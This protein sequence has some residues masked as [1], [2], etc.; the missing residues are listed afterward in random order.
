MMRIG[1]QAGFT[2][3][4]VIVALA[5][6]A[7]TLGGLVKSVGDTASNQHT[8]EERTLAQWV[9]LNRMALTQLAETPA[10][11]GASNGVTKM[12][13][14][15]WQWSQQID[16]TAD[17]AVNRITVIVNRD[18]NESQLARVIGFLGGER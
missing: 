12:A 10:A 1:R 16:N 8:L 3:L 11:A 15:Q 2:L 18:G 9:A 14:R 13:G 7:L 5:I 6:L 4:E 17:S